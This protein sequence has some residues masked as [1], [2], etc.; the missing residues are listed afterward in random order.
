LVKT[1]ADDGAQVRQ[2]LSARAASMRR[3]LLAEDDVEAK[4]RKQLMGLA[5]LLIA[6]GFMLFVGYPAFVNIS[7]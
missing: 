1:V 7:L 5:G 4:R 3:A 6:A 2:T